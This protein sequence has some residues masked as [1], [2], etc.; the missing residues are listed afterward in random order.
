VLRDEE[1]VQP[2]P[3]T[4]DF[5]VLVAAVKAFVVGC[6]PHVLTTCVPSACLGVGLPVCCAALAS[7][8]LPACPA[9]FLA[10]LQ[11]TVA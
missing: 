4:S 2:G 9:A 1:A 5:W 11:H 7:C 10:L 8:L 3:S 6:P